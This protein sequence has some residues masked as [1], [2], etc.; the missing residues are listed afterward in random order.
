MMKGF[1]DY[2]IVASLYMAVSS[3][4]YMVMLGRD[5]QYARNRI[6]ILASLAM[7]M[8]LPFLRINLPDGSTLSEIGNGLT[9]IVYVGEVLVTPGNIGPTAN[10]TLT[11]LAAIY[12]TGALASLALLLTNLAVMKKLV[13]EKGKAGSRIVFTGNPEISGFSAIGHIFVGSALDP[14][15]LQRITEHE[16]KHLD[17][18]HF[19][20][21]L[22][23][24][25]TSVI[26]WF[27][28]FVYLLERSL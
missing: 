22:F 21:L 1:I 19:A 25:A 11:V 16:Q 26:F 9:R 3:I 17:Y 5:T 2:I 14:E 12:I 27:N 4:Y 24:R 10:P 28:P 6:F 23:V 18:N 8:L 7:S 15:E 20:D 13:R